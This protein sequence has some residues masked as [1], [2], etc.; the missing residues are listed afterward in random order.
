LLVELGK[1]LPTFDPDSMKIAAASMT[2]IL[3]RETEHLLK[4]AGAKYPILFER[5][6]LAS[7]E[8]AGGP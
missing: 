6:I 3:K 2:I 7:Q 8:S 5:T 4:S 1:T